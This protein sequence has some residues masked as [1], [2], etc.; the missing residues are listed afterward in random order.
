MYHALFFKRV[1]MCCHI[2]CLF[3][4]F[5]PSLSFSLSLSFFSLPSHSVVAT[6]ALCSLNAWSW[7]PVLGLSLAVF[8]SWNIISSDIC[9]TSSLIPSV[10]KCHLLRDIFLD[11]PFQN[12]PQLSL[13]P[14]LCI[15]SQR[16]LLDMIIYIYLFPFFLLS[17]LPPLGYKFQKA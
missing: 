1:F 7:F 2:A 4:P 14:T 5:P 17:P 16:L 6:L 11:H 12:S 9:I 10:L 13:F 15:S 8:S 3:F